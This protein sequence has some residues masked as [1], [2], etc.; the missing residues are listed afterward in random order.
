MRTIRRIQT[1]GLLRGLSHATI[2]GAVLLSMAACADDASVS[3]GDTDLR[4][5]II[6]VGT[7]NMP[8]QTDEKP[9]NTRILIY[10]ADQL[11]VINQDK[12]SAIYDKDLALDAVPR[13]IDTGIPYP[14]GDRVY[15]MGYTHREILDAEREKLVNEDHSLPASMYYLPGRDGTDSVFYTSNCVDGTYH[16]PISRPLEFR[17]ATVRLRFFVRIDAQ[18]M[19]NAQKMYARNVSVT[20]PAEYIP[21]VLRFDVEE[22]RYVLA[23]H[24]GQNDALASRYGTLNDK[25]EVLNEGFRMLEQCLYL[26]PAKTTAGDNTF[27]LKGVKIQADY[28][29]PGSTD[30]DRKEWIMDIEL[31][32]LDKN[33]ITGIEGGQSYDLQLTFGRNS[34]E[35]EACEADWE[36][37]SSIPIPVPDTNGQ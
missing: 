29:R 35:I 1:T 22:R 33:S 6:D 23:N 2:A 12:A 4:T 3:A 20:I 27:T 32:D 13:H 15:A 31:K 19:L 34:F 10:R 11:E 26:A 17:R 5:M 18:T 25:G 28:H 24:T 30:F 8:V 21:N 37:N 36:I 16:T 14:P 7:R 9:L